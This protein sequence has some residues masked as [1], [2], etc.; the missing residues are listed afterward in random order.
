MTRHDWAECTD[1][2]A[3]LQFIGTNP[4]DRKLRLFGC[5]CFRRVWDHLASPDVK[6]I[7]EFAER[8]ADGLESSDGLRS[9][10]KRAIEIEARLPQQIGKVRELVVE[11]AN[12]VAH[13][14][15]KEAVAERS[16]RAMFP[17]E[18][19]REER[20][21]QCAVLRDLIGDPFAEQIDFAPWRTDRTVGIALQAYE[22]Y[23]FD[24]LPILADALVDEDCNNSFVLAHCRS[25]QQHF[26]GCWVVDGLLGKA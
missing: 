10:L 6:Q 1:P 17:R 9:M 13:E 22:E 15:P 24:V 25:G 21:A 23:R 14:A 3:L 12:W 26:R 2:E 7:V 18:I 8:Y 20:Q 4:G 5:A 11:E 19:W 16:V